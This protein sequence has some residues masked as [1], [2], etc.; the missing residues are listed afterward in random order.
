MIRYGNVDAIRRDARLHL[1]EALCVASSLQKGNHIGIEFRVVVEDGITIRTSIGKGFPQLL[2]HP[3]S[4]RMMSDAEVQ[5]PAPAML[6]YEEAIQ[7]LERQRGHGKKVEGK[8][9]PHDG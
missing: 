9:S 8:R 1:G 6:D 5:N 7:E 2:H 3:L 4:S